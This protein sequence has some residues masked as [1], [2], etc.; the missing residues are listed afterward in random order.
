MD[1][2]I[3]TLAAPSSPHCAVMRTPTNDSSPEP[4]LLLRRGTVGLASLA[5]L[6]EDERFAIY[7][8]SE[9]T[10]PWLALARQLAAIVVATETDPLN[11]FGYA[12]TASPNVPIIMLVER[13]FAHS[14]GDVL[15]AGASA[16]VY[17]PL[18]RDRNAKL[19]VELRRHA[20][21]ARVDTNARLLIDP[22][23]R[24]V[25]RG[26]RSAH[27]THLEYRILHHLSAAHGRAI[28]AEDLIA[29]IWS[30]RPCAK[31]R[32]GLE[33][34]VS[35]LRKKLGTLGLADALST[36]RGFGY[37]FVGKAPEGERPMQMPAHTDNP[38]G[39]TARSGS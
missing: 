18:D 36:V 28:A 4:V 19:L 5:A 34:H 37:A 31:P 7:H 1:V 2:I 32:A 15:K 33:V 25:R 30:D 13:R 12:V 10:P 39:A 29:T 14:A 11:A 3:A 21:L 9:L 23:T 6:Y 17:V 8:T 27:L 26:D 24:T 38:S 35:Q 16:C 20:R 22:V